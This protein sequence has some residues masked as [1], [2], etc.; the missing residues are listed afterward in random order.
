[1]IKELKVIID[2]FLPWYLKFL[3]WSQEY[4]LWVYHH[5]QWK[6]FEGM[7]VASGIPAWYYALMNHIYEFTVYCTS[8]VARTADGSI[9]HGR[10]LDYGYPELFK[11]I[12]YHGVFTKG[13]EVLYRGT[14]F[15][16]CVGIY[17][18]ERPG[19][20]AIS[21]DTRH[22]LE[23]MGQIK[24]LLRI[25]TG[26]TQQ[27]LLIRQVLERKDNYADAL[28]DLTYRR[29]INA[30]YFVISG[31]EGNE[32]AVISRDHDGPAHIDY[33]DD[34][35]WWVHVAN[36]D[37]WAGDCPERCQNARDALAYYG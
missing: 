16:G 21:Q 8:I 18:G 11:Y 33:L 26:G 9:I 3:F 28:K 10:N 20:F 17:T 19:A 27:S 31:L 32:G 24:N 15:A 7:A 36:Q 25:F 2:E 12:T 14:M 23:P 34:E 37:H 6:E 13:G 4:L 1:M 30:G 5:E 29:T 22:P 35:H